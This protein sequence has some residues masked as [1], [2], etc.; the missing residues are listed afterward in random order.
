MQSLFFSTILRLAIATFY[1][2]KK[3]KYSGE[4]FKHNHRFLTITSFW[5]SEQIRTFVLEINEI[6]EKGIMGLIYKGFRE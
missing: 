2:K 1:T 3:M 4:T 5:K 6:L